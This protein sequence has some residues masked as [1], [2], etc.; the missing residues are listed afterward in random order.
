MAVSNKEKALLLNTG[1]KTEIAL[2]YCTMYGDMAGA[3]GVI[4]DLNKT[5]IFI[6]SSLS[7]LIIFFGIYPDPVFNT[8]KVS[9][10][11]L[12]ENYNYNLTVYL[13]NL[14]N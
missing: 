3:L 11:H 1:N 5:E 6:L 12:I 9:I 10:S 2:G 4:S 14:N 13:S 8:I 7:I